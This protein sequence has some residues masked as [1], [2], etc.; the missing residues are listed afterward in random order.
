MVVEVEAEN[1]TDAERQVSDNWK[2]CEYIL[3]SD[4]FLD[5]SFRA[6]PKE[7]QRDAPVR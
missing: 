2:N 4:H 3:D 6:K 1:R 5:V 7:S